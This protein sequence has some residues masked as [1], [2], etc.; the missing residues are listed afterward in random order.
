M[1]DTRNP[2]SVLTSNPHRANPRRASLACPARP[3]VRRTRRRRPDGI[4]LLIVLVLLALFT[5][6]LISFVVATS[7]NRQSVMQSAR[8]EQTGDT[9]QTQLY[10]AFMQ[11]V[12]GS[13]DGNSIMGPHSLLEDMYG[14]NTGATGVPVNPTFPTSAAIA[15][16]ARS[17]RVRPAFLPTAL[18]T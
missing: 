3:G 8:I 1:S 18:A 5:M 16:S 6:L 17:C 13:R 7:T 14:Q 2:G 9:P 11:V 4:I 10:D 12:R 15:C